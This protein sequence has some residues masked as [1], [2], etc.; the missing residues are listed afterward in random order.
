[1]V[2]RTRSVA[3]APD[4]WISMRNGSFARTWGLMDTSAAVTAVV[5]CAL[6]TPAAKPDADDPY[7]QFQ[8]PDDLMW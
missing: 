8:V 3:T 2:T 5:V 4:A 1:M 7:A 6:A